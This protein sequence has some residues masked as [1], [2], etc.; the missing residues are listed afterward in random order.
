MLV[1]VMFF[2]FRLIEWKNV[3]CWY[4][5]CGV[6]LLSSLVRLLWIVLGF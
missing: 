5:G 1:R 2:R 6:W 3:G 4:F